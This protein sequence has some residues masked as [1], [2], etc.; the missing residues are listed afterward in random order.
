MDKDE[1]PRLPMITV[2]AECETAGCFLG[3]T[4]CEEYGFAD[5]VQ[6]QVTLIDLHDC[7]PEANIIA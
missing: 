5:T 2:C 7:W 1:G 4:P 6:V 3:I